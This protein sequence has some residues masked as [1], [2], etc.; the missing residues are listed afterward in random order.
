MK[1]AALLAFVFLA[2]FH[3]APEGVV[4]EWKDRVVEQPAVIEFK[5]VATPLCPHHRRKDDEYKF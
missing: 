5:Q 4:V 2:H 3:L 1:A